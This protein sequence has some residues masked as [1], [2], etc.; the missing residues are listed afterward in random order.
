MLWG[1]DL[2]DLI[3]ELKEKI[4]FTNILEENCNVLNLYYI[5]TKYPDAS[6]NG[7]PSEKSSKSQTE[8]AIRLASEVVEFGESKIF[9]D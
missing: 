2:I 3:K 5:S 4:R 1:H 8:R 6:T 7:Y 9:E